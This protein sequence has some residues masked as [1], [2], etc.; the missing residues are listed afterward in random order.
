MKFYWLIFYHFKSAFAGLVRFLITSWFSERFS[1]GMSMQSVCRCI[2]GSST[3]AS[4]FFVADSCW[5]A[6]RGRWLLRGRPCSP[7]VL[8]ERKK[9]GPQ[10]T[11]RSC[12]GLPD[13]DARTSGE[14]R[15]PKLWSVARNCVVSSDGTSC[16]KVVPT[17]GG[18][19]HSTPPPVMKSRYK[20]RMKIIIFTQNRLDSDRQIGHVSQIFSDAAVRRH[21]R[22][23][24]TVGEVVCHRGM[25][26]R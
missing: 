1:V 4:M 18:S 14:E 20:F 22:L 8:E 13:G 6:L 24:A 21:A 25:V 10:F 26:R 17:N 19:R 23:T 11:W 2:A 16:H 9:R 15:V 7:F 3:R 5:F 12:R